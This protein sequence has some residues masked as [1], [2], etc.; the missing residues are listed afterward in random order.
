MYIWSKFECQFTCIFKSKISNCLVAKQVK[1]YKIINKHRK[2][3]P[4]VIYPVKHVSKYNKF[5][6][7]PG[8]TLQCKLQI[9]VLMK[10]I[11]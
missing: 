5:K 3:P 1:K 4:K 10:K 7:Y 8:H 2:I 11:V 6:T 9:S